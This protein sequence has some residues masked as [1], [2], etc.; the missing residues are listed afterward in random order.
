MSDSALH[1]VDVEVSGVG[2]IDLA[3]RVRGWLLAE[4]IIVAQY[5]QG[6]PAVDAFGV[7]VGVARSLA[8]P[9]DAS[10]ML[11]AGVQ[12]EQGRTMFHGGE[13]GL[14]DVL[15]P[16][17]GFRAIATDRE[18]YA[19]WWEPACEML[20]RWHRNGGTTAVRCPHCA[21]PT[22]FNDWQAGDDPWAI[23][24]FAITLWNWPPPSQTFTSSLIEQ[25][26]G[27]RTV[28]VNA[29]F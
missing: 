3:H 26:G 8:D 29:H 22:G 15:C 28:M 27:H 20:T 2:V 13:S 4:Q 1:I 24:E 7:G 23:G 14:P 6:A 25:L 10:T 9:V 19:P 18:R 21:A 17:C 11:G 12:V 16:R 5:A